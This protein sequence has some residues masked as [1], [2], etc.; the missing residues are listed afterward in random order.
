MTRSADSRLEPAFLPRE[1][2]D[3]VLLDFERVMLGLVPWLVP[4]NHSNNSK[5]W[6]APTCLCR[7]KLPMTVMIA[8]NSASAIWQ[9]TIE[10]QTSEL[11]PDAARALLRLKFSPAD[12]DRAN[13]LAAK[14]RAE[15]LTAA[16]ERELEDYRAVGTALEFIKCKARLSLKRTRR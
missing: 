13:E 6:L 8:E 9:R 7:Y 4:S 12:L 11:D 16:E 14:A 15:R 10:T 5:P 2:P 1:D 3:S